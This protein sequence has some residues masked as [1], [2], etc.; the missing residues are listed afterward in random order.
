M[1]VLITRQPG[2][3][4][5]VADISLT[6]EDLMKQYLSGDDGAFEAVY[7]RRREGLR[8]F[9]ARQCGSPAVGDELAHETW[10]KLV[11]AC[12]SG[13]YT[14]EAKFTTYLYKLAKNQLIDWYRKNKNYE[15][16]DFDE[17]V[18]GDEE[19]LDTFNIDIANPEEI[20]GD[21][22]KAQILMRA[23][24]ELSDVQKATLLMHL[25]GDMSYEEI[26]EVMNTNRETV[27]TRLRYARQHLKNK[28]LGTQ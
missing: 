16:V 15:T 17:T 3:E 27:K 8:R 20:Y 7:R 1:A 25:E 19:V 12:R 11:R 23:I 10:F 5:T 28:V 9:F 26:A 14:A 18:V 4:M 24:D 22:Q 21:K 13:Q 2:A 6:D